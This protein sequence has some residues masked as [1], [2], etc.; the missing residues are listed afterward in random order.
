MHNT[1][2]PL[3]FR[4]SSARSSALFAAILT[5]ALIAAPRA[6]SQDAKAPVGASSVIEDRKAKQMI[7]AGDARYDANEIEP[8]IELYKAAI[9]RY[10]ASKWRYLAHLKIGRHA[11]LKDRKYEVA[12]DQFRR[13]AAAENKDIDQVAEASLFIGRTLFEMQK[14]EESFTAL[15]DVIKNFPDTPYCNDA[16]FYIGQGHF[17]LGRFNRAIEAFK[18]VG[19]ALGK[20]G[21]E[22]DRL[23]IGKR[24]FI[25]IDDQDLTAMASNEGIRV[26]IETPSGD[27]E[28]VLCV[29]STPGSPTLMGSIKTVLGDASK[30]NGVLE[31]SG[32]DTIKVTYVDRQTA[33]GKLNQVRTREIRAV[34]QAR[35]EVV[36]GAFADP[37]GAVVLEKPAFLRVRD[38]DRDIS[39]KQ[40]KLEAIVRIKRLEEAEPVAKA[41]A[42]TSTDPD[43]K[44]VPK[45]KVIAEKT[46]TLLE[47]ITNPTNQTV[48]SE[49]F[50]GSIMI[51]HE[52]AT[53]SPAALRAN[54]G[55]LLE[56][57]YRDEL[58]LSGKPT[59]RISAVK[60]IEGNLSPLQVAEANVNDEEL[61][62]RIPLE[63]TEALTKIGNI[64]KEMGLNSQAKDKYK[65]AL[66][67]VERVARAHGS[68]NP[69]LL[70]RT[71]VQTWKIYYAM[72][73]LNRAAA[74]CVELQRRFPNS[75]F[76]GDA[77][78][79]MAQVA[80]KKG[81]FMEAV[82][83]YR[84]LAG[85]KSPLA[86]EA[87]FGIGAALEAAAEAQKQKTYLDEAFRAYKTCAEKFPASK[88][89]GDALSR[90]ADY[91]YNKEDYSR[92]IDIYEEAIKMNQDSKFLD[93]ILYGYGRCLVKMKRLDAALEKFRTL[94]LTYPNSPLAPKAKQI[95][96]AIEKK[97]TGASASAAP[98]AK[99]E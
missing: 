4:K 82:G 15:R 94:M 7:E 12:L 70:E 47:Q 67:E 10:P 8:A 38:A 40:D 45:Y 1:F 46:V 50:V 68:M 35:A 49:A 59:N 21:A 92:A 18:N 60:I 27:R 28:E 9:D 72:D 53:N 34:G 11:F 95:A 71:Y 84:R 88:F 37:V 5:L 64:Y 17:K 98:A 87:Q 66:E 69:R 93:N 58:N 24:L 44:P 85:I 26:L 41:G 76:V 43:E 51:A 78:L 61:K 90:M 89:A 65:Q 22:I 3:L 83:V 73:D 79:L 39:T 23:E 97:L 16:Y 6:Q 86:A 99:S 2:F 19:T 77:L 57:E 29:S 25:R 74:Q 20:D 32:T 96:E 42:S 13:V 48:H 62:V 14:F 56:I 91:Y 54:V 52:G 30:T 55:D 31:L 63:T 75:P 36:D 81:N 33:D 80:Q